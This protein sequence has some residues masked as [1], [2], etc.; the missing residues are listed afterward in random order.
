[1]GG[2]GGCAE[3]RYSL[4]GYALESTLPSA[5]LCAPR[6]SGSRESRFERW[7]SCGE[8]RDEVY[9]KSGSALC[10]FECVCVAWV[11][12]TAARKRS[13]G[14]KGEEVTGRGAGVGASLGA[15][16]FSHTACICARILF[17]YASVHALAADKRQRAGGE[18]WRGVSGGVCVCARRVCVVSRRRE[19]RGGVQVL[20]AA[21]VGN[22]AS[23]QRW[24]T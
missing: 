11:G 1:M 20:E 21:R 13:R 14:K 15:G 18:R 10:E 2:C 12:V 6:A 17:W 19:G 23:R 8:E 24:R 7:E 3:A 4:A 5:L 9:L 22:V 16:P